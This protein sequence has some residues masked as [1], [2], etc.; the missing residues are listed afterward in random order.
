MSEIWAP[1]YHRQ[2]RERMK[3]WRRGVRTAAG[4]ANVDGVVAGVVDA[5]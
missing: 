5:A 1:S 2:F 3:T 4:E